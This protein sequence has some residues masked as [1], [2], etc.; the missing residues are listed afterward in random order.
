MSQVVHETTLQGVRPFFGCN[1]EIRGEYFT[2]LNY[3]GS[4]FSV[5]INNGNVPMINSQPVFQLLLCQNYT[6][7]QVGEELFIHENM[8]DLVANTAAFHRL[9]D[10]SANK[11]NGVA[12]NAFAE[13][14]LNAVYRGWDNLPS[15]VRKF[16]STHLHVLVKGA[17]GNS[18]VQPADV[19]SAAGV[20]SAN[21]RLNLT[22]VNKAD[23]N[24][25]I[26]F[27]E[28][29]PK[30]TNVVRGF[31]VTIAG[32]VVTVPITPGAPEDLLKQIYNSV[33]SSGSVTVAGNNYGA[34][35][36]V[37]C[38]QVKLDF[39]LD[40]VKFSKNVILA[41]AQGA[42]PKQAA[43]AAAASLNKDNFDD[44]FTSLTTGVTFMRD[45]DGQLFRID[46]NDKTKMDQSQ[47]ELDIKNDGCHG[48]KINSGD[49]DVVFQCLL[50]GNP[51]NLS[52]CLGK[53]KN[54]NMFKIAQREV[55]LM[56]PQ[57]ATQLLR[58][59]GFTPRKELP[60]G[61]VLPPSF[62]EWRQN[63]LPNSVNTETQEAIVDN[64]Q[65]MNYLKGVV[66][67]IRNNPTVLDENK[68]SSQNT[69]STYASRAGLKFFVQ[70][71]ST[72][73]KAQVAANILEQGVLLSR[74][75][76]NSMPLAGLFN[77]IGMNMN[78]M[79]SPFALQGGGAK[80]NCPN[81][82]MLKNMFDVTYSEMERNGKVLV[83]ADKKRIDDSVKRVAH[84]EEQ[85]VR[86]LEDLKLFT[87]L[88]TTFSIGRAPIGVDEVSLR[89][90][91]GASQASSVT[92][93]AI[94]NLKNCASQNITEQS[95]LMGDMVLQIQK[96]LV[97]TMTGGKNP[98]LERVYSG[99]M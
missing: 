66:S 93:E 8:I 39:K 3:L 75:T 14:L 19:A 24:S 44:I 38:D 49:C 68:N 36:Y 48:T 23:S 5:A 42:S 70:P 10:D 50:S 71:I 30:L 97:G 81:A 98:L 52:R 11:G 84:L 77:N 29:L 78:M 33:Y 91:V 12:G 9:V 18:W 74:P 32:S 59:F 57:V 86:I 20:V 80:P 41:H 1:S 94:G 43:A 69:M 45:K 95:K 64:A 96:S 63:I 35:A 54:E 53:L 25:G 73:E 4:E 40:A 37:N 55:E 60:H 82:N 79:S 28:T 27:A 2:H 56:N 99:R 17:D 72:S 67:L 87:K 58:T 90:V 7:C 46:G 83:D 15:D 62:D 22:K 31:K 51:S 6:N 76:V 88:N 26:L 89:D 13:Y 85:L 47:L 65:L 16:Y 61:L 92:G 34:F 21:V